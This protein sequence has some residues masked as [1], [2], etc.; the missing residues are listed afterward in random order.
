MQSMSEKTAASLRVGM[1][2]YVQPAWRASAPLQ[3]FPR[4]AG[5]PQDQYVSALSM[6]EREDEEILLP[7]ERGPIVFKDGIFQ[8]DMSK[9]EEKG[10]IDQE[11]KKLIDSI[12]GE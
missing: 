1:R 8:I 2:T 10:D 5:M 4:P 9:V 6:L 7:P 11:L 12:M 3:V